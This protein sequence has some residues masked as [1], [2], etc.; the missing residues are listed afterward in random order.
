MRYIYARNA[1]RVSDAVLNMAGYTRALIEGGGERDEQAVQRDSQEALH[2]R[3]K[4]KPDFTNPFDEP[5]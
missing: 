3:S 5:N 4:R 1:V 2:D